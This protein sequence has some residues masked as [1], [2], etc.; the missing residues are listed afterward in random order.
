MRFKAATYI[1]IFR[2]FNN[3]QF[4][5]MTGLFT[6]LLCDTVELNKLKAGVRSK[7]GRTANAACEAA[8]SYANADL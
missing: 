4:F 5:W 3:L 6:D 2:I 7:I 8:Q 1:T